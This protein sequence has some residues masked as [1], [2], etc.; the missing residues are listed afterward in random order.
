MYVVNSALTIHCDHMHSNPALY[1]SGP[2]LT[3]AILRFF[4][5]VLN[6]TQILGQYHKLRCVSVL[7]LPDLPFTYCASDY[8]V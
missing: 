1:L 6:C 8:L 5:T 2:E 4:M 3:P 7:P